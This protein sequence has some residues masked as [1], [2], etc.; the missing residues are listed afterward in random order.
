MQ[1][2]IYFFSLALNVSLMELNV[3]SF[4][5]EIRDARAAFEKYIVC[6]D[7]TPDQ[8]E[9]SIRSLMTKAI[10]AYVTR[11]PNLRHGIALDKQVTIIISQTDAE[12]P[13][14]GIYFNLHTPYL[15][16]SRRSLKTEDPTA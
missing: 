4:Q 5:P 11:A 3:E 6:L 16:R 15:K 14:C 10:H 2:M 12:R 13:N 1:V 9:T 8:F 7:K